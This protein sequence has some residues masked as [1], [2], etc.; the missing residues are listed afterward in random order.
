MTL[1]VATR[2]EVITATPSAR[3]AAAKAKTRVTT[4]P[5]TSAA[6]KVTTTT[7]TSM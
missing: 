5:V 3:L 6:T 4:R 2:S 1:V 7:L